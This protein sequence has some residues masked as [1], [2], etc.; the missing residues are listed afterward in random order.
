M[1]LLV[2]SC[3][4]YHLSCSPSPTS[5]HCAGADDPKKTITSDHRGF[6]RVRPFKNQ[7]SYDEDILNGAEVVEPQFVLR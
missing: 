1:S 7:T 6:A 2:I 5:S 3:G 4:G